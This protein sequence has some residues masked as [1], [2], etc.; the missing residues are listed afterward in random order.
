MSRQSS[1]LFIGFVTGTLLILFL[2]F[3]AAG[4]FVAGRRSVATPAEIQ[5]TSQQDLAQ[6]REYA[7]VSAMQNQIIEETPTITLSPTTVATPTSNGSGD[8]TR[9][10]ESPIEE[11]PTAEPHLDE[12]LPVSP[13]DLSEVDLELLLEVWD[14]VDQ[15][16]DGELPTNEEVTYGA[17][18][19]S[20]ELLDDPF[21]QFLPP[22][23]AERS[24]EQLE[25]RFEG[26]GAFVSMNEEGFLL[27]A[28]PF[29][30]QPADLAGI[31]SGDL[32]TRVDGKS[33]LGMTLE[34]I[35]N[36]VKG[37]EGTEVILTIQR[38]GV[39][40]SFDVVVVRARIEIPIVELSILENNVGY[41]RL[42]SFSSDVA[43]QL[44]EA[45]QSVLGQQPVGLILDLRDNPGGFLDES[46]AVADLFLPE[47]VILYQ[48]N[49]KGES[50]T[51]MSKTG[52]Q[53][54]TIELVV[55]I[56]GGSAS[57]SE[58]V[59]GAIQDT[60]RGTL[61]GETSFG[62]GSVQQTH[63]LSDGSDLRVTVARWYTPENKSID[64][65]G[66]TPDIEVMTPE[67]FGGEDD[68]QLQRAVQYI[69]TGE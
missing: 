13:A 67:E 35:I 7:D 38:E 30:G 45:L 50:E 26:I 43:Q 56:N 60:G 39:A 27:I 63:R 33:V 31:K 5:P 28:R 3:V 12:Q 18:R 15:E 47:G 64:H 8:A 61:I 2:A 65:E 44:T 24:R 41:I 40:E 34:E 62:K 21:T 1:K 68:T 37:P 48:R 4:A 32:V 11:T 36:S 14:I 49:N 20:L 9:E 17:I 42:S 23:I 25:G 58:I 6:T 57:A 66:I 19:G 52:D 55:L 46:V 69:L 53:A 54:E 51:F 29:E 22:E 16:F 59:A 10:E